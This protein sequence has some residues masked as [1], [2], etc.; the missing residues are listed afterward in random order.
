MDTGIPSRL[1]RTI[2]NQPRASSC[3]CFPYTRHLAHLFPEK[4]KAAKMY[5]FVEFRRVYRSLP[6]GENR[7]DVADS[8]ACF[9]SRVW[10]RWL[11]TR[12]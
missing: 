11:T 5:Q 3:Y 12:H 2:I 8:V 6:S 4:D 7:H 10:C 9:S 1:A